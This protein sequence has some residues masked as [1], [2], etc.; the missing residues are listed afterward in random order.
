MNLQRDRPGARGFSH[1]RP[2]GRNSD[3]TTVEDLQMDVTRGQGWRGQGVIVRK[4]EP[5]KE[6]SGGGGLPGLTRG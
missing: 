6:G 4:S 1:V 2:C 3:L 5:A